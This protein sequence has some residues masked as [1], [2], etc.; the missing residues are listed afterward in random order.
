VLV[1]VLLGIGALTTAVIVLRRWHADD[2]PEPV[3]SRLRA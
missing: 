1:G 2:H 3:E